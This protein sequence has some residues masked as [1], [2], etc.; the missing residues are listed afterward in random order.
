[1][2]TTMN[3]DGTLLAEARKASGAKNNTDTVRLG[4]ESL[5]RRAA[6][7]RLI[8]YREPEAT[9]V[10]RRREAPAGNRRQRSALAHRAR[11]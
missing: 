3:I 5:V 2:K 10:P 9:D 6:V 7:E 11:A 1:M 8:A 4:L